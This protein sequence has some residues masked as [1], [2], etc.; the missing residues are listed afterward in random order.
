MF[1]D[2]NRTHTMTVALLECPS[3]ITCCRGCLCKGALPSK[4]RHGST[5]ADDRPALVHN[6]IDRVDTRIA[7]VQ[8]D[9]ALVTR[10]EAND[11]VLQYPLTPEARHASQTE[12]PKHMPM[13]RRSSG[14]HALRAQVSTTGSVNQGSLSTET[15]DWA[16]APCSALQGIGQWRAVPMAGLAGLIH[17]PADCT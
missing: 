9:A 10:P 11:P 17:N 3:K 15:R 2:D 5:S 13:C 8:P 1:Y 7:T 16:R 14:R 6:S 4:N 12:L